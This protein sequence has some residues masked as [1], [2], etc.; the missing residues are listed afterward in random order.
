MHLPEY[1]K[2]I[3]DTL[4]KNGFPAYVVGGCVRDSLMNRSPKDY[5]IATAAQPEELCRIFPRTVLTGEK[6]GT[7]T[8]LGEKPVEVTT[9]RIDGV[10]HDGRRPEEVRFTA[11]M[12]EDLSRRDLTINAIAYNEKK[13]YVDPFGGREDIAS[14]VLRAVGEPR[15]RFQEDALRILRVFR[16]SAEL[17]F[18]IE[19]RTLAA[20]FQEMESLSKVST[21]RI[22]IEIYKSLDGAHADNLLPLLQ[23]GGLSHLG[24]QRPQVDFS[25]EALPKRRCCRLAA[26]LYGCGGG[27]G[28]AILPRLRADNQTK[29]LTGAI[30]DQLERPL[31]LTPVGVKERFRTIPP[32]VFPDFLCTYG[33]LH[34][35]SVEKSL[36]MASGIIEK[37]EPWNLAMLDISGRELIEMGL[38]EGKSVGEMLTVLLGC[39][40]EHPG[41]NQ[42]KTLQKMVREHKNKFFGDPVL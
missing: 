16:F 8:V 33:A 2:I 11:R 17:G 36:A 22:L 1:V 41:M 7:V 39:V 12:E 6:Y 40:M 3:L 4:I 35:I 13:G 38:P 9:F 28:W 30:L 29:R 34:H 14:G 42:R 37:G 18:S 20:C 32:E 10:Y 31:P 21:E 25:L 15:R 24:F 23:N 27:A 5:D 26:L 19:P